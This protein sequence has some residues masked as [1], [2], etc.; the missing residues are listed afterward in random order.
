MKRDLTFS[1]I[2]GLFVGS[3]VFFT[4]N[5]VRSFIPV[6][7]PGFVLALA[8]FIVLLVIALIEMPMM[9]F[10]LRKMAQSTTPP[11]IIAA[12]FAFYAMFAA[13]YASIFIL[14]TDVNYFYLG[15]ILAAVGIARFVSGIFIR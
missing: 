3:L 9:V 11:K 13:V 7:L 14:L 4:S 1:G 10:A 12:G 5:W 2:L 8:T 15:A 6:L